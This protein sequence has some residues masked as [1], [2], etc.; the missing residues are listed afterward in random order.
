MH[1]GGIRGLT[2][3][4]LG[5]ERYLERCRCAL[6]LLLMWARVGFEDRGE[7]FLSEIQKKKTSPPTLRQAD[8]TAYLGAEAV[9]GATIAGAWAW[10]SSIPY[11]KTAQ[12]TRE[13]RLRFRQ[14]SQ[15]VRHSWLL[16]THR[17]ATASGTHVEHAIRTLIFRCFSFPLPRTAG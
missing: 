5:A 10:R 13:L 8:L 16:L 2:R 17:W 6:I 12:N 7:R 1:L 14:L 3:C 4:N 9:D 15:T 11:A